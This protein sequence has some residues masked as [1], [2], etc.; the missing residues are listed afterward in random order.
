MNLKNGQLK[1]IAKKTLGKRYYGM[2]VCH[3][4]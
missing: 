4:R 1:L 3:G 2:Q